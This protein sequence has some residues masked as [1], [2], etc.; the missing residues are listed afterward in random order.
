MPASAPTHQDTAMS[1]AWSALAD[2]IR[3]FG[4]AATTRGDSLDQAEGLRHTLR[5]LGH[6]ADFHLEHTDPLRPQFWR[7]ITQT[8]KYYGDG[9]DVDYDT[10]RIDGRY[11]YRITG[12]PGTVPYL[13]FIVNRKGLGNRF[14]GNIVIG[15]EHLRADGTFEIWLAAHIGERPG[16]K[17][18][19]QC[20]EVVARQYHQDRSGEV[21][22]EF[23]I[24][25]VGAA[26]PPREPLDTSA[27]TASLRR[28]GY[29]LDVSLKRLDGLVEEISR[30]PNVVKNS[31]G[32]AGAE[33]FGTTSNQYQVGWW[34]LDDDEVLEM[35]FAPADAR[36]FS[37]QLFNRWFESLE[38]RD[39]VTSLNN[40][41]ITAEPSGEMVVHIGESD[42][43]VNR[44]DPCGHRSGIILVRYLEGA[45]NPSEP[46]VRV[47]KC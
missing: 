35:T 15:E 24:E 21:P 45:T 34:D 27:V 47:V 36:Y 33:F 40:S 12:T 23:T 3:A 29:G 30:D 20:V 25:R 14:A 5:F 32:S 16:L 42:G 39:H 44:L 41:Q 28:I 43:P 37:V 13:A 22:A 11:T 18:D 38:F 19:E 4:E 2:Q 7:A 6:L 31:S 1:T 17:I 26:V 46:R 8:R 9:V 10:C